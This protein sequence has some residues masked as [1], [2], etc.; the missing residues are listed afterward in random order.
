MRLR[1]RAGWRAHLLAT[2][3]NYYRAVSEKIR[4]APTFMLATGRVGGAER[5]MA[6]SYRDLSPLDWPQLK[7]LLWEDIEPNR[8]GA[9]P[10][11]DIAARVNGKCRSSVP[12]SA[13]GC[14]AA[15]DA[16][17]DGGRRSDLRAQ[18]HNAAPLARG[19]NRRMAP[20]SDYARAGVAAVAARTA[21]L[22]RQPESIKKTE[23]P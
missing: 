3:H 7:C 13:A 10:W 8:H 4:R 21:P 18:L 5:S 11:D 9:P 2:S 15:F 20:Q 6:L 17:P 16:V 22:P 19:R 23:W 12:Q 14:A 1:M